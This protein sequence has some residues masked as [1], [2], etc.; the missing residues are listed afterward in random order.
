[1]LAAGHDFSRVIE[2]AGKVWEVDHVAVGAGARLPRLSVPDEGQYVVADWVV[3]SPQTP[4]ALSIDGSAEEQGLLS[5]IRYSG[6]DAIVVDPGQEVSLD[7]RGDEADITQA[8]LVLY[9]RVD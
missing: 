2:Q 6:R 1:M 3:A 5:G 7:I 4:Y 9:R 8:A